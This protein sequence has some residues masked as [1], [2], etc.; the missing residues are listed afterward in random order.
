MQWQRS[1]IQYQAFQPAMR[2]QPWVSKV[3]T[4]QVG[5]VNPAT[6]FPVLPDGK[7]RIVFSWDASHLNLWFGAPITNHYLE[8]VRANVNYFGL[9]FY[10]GAASSLS[11]APM[12]ELNNSMEDLFE[13]ILPRESREQWLTK[14]NTPNCFNFI[15]TKIHQSLVKQTKNTDSFDRIKSA[16]QPLIFSNRSVDQISQELQMNRRQLLRL[17]SR[18]VGLSP[19]QLR[20]IGRA[21]MVLMSLNNPTPC[22]LG[23]PTNSLTQLAHWANYHDQAHMNHDFLTLFGSSPGEMKKTA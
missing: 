15:Q 20:R 11:P 5:D 17:F 16:F 13:L 8:R 10:C 18:H 3:W 12:G 9:E 19:V 1:G 14:L 21:Q 7:S 2:L 6:L 22:V 4:M 23:N